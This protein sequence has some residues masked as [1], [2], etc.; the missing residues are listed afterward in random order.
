MYIE[1]LRFMKNV[2]TRTYDGYHDD[3][4]ENVLYTYCNDVMIHEKWWWS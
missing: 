4:Y 2:H 1:E 3:T